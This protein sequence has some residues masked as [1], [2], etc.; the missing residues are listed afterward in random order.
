MNIKKKHFFYVS[1]L[2]Y[3]LIFLSISKKKPKQDEGI[4][5]PLN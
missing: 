1:C 5:E 2:N 3:C 4:S